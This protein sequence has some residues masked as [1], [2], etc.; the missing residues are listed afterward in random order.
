MKCELAEAPESSGIWNLVPEFWNRVTDAK[1]REDLSKA[2]IIF[3]NLSKDGNVRNAAMSFLEGIWVSLEDSTERQILDLSKSLDSTEAQVT[4]GK[5][6]GID[7]QKVRDDR[8]SMGERTL[9]RIS[10]VI[11][12]RDCLPSNSIEDLFILALEAG[13]IGP[14]E[15]WLELFKFHKSIFDID[16]KIKLGTRC[17]ELINIG[18]YDQSYSTLL[19]STLIE[20]LTNAPLERTR[21]LVVGYFEL[22]KSQN[23]NSARI[24]G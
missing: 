13:Q 19:L 17:L 10:L 6:V 16:F 14:L 24:R 12:H 22:L 8:Q 9:F 20:A 7:L 18:R 21:E 2:A 4:R 15:R 11:D 3:A 5:L 23:A 1:G